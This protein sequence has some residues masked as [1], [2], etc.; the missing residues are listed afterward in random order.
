M[1][2]AKTQR[3]IFLVKQNPALEI[4]FTAADAARVVF[5]HHDLLMITVQVSNCTMKKVFV[6]SGSSINIILK[7]T[8]DQMKLPS[9]ILKLGSEPIFGFNNTTTIPVGSTSAYYARA[10]HKPFYASFLIIDQPS[11]YNAF[12]GRPALIDLGQ[13]FPKRTFS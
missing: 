1:R 8:Y 10:L 2:E 3:A 12:L 6:D 13:S 11:P 5:S 7:S 4:T 9:E